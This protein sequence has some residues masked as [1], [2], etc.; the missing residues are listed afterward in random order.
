MSD[1]NSETDYDSENE[2][3][4]NNN[5]DD[6]N[7]DESNPYI[8]KI[9]IEYKYVKP[10]Y[11]SS[12]YPNIYEKRR[13]FEGS[14][15]Y[16]NNWIEC[17]YCGKY[18]PESMHLPD[19]HYCGHCWGWL[20]AQQ[21]NLIDCSYNGPNTIEEIKNFLKMTYPLHSSKCI[22]TE[23][24][25]N[26]IKEFGENKTLNIELCFNLGF[27]VKEEKKQKSSKNYQYKINKDKTYINI[28]Y[29]LS[30]ISI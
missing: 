18:H 13:E 25:Y 15:N 2:N 14:F 28:D 8:P 27:I 16:K 24:I 1:Y 26:K 11:D 6:E 19:I 23:C 7:N 3:Q 12:N 20:N 21:M 30:S 9:K 10:Y 17:F 22:N 5:Q 4:I 29:K